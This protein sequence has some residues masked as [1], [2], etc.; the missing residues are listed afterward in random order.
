MRR[1][2]WPE[3]ILRALLPFRDLSWVEIGEEFTR[4]TLLWTPFF[5]IYLHRMWS[6][7]PAAKCHDHPWSFLSIPLLRGYCEIIPGDTTFVTVR[8]MLPGMIKWHPA[9]YA[10]NTFTPF[11]ISWSMILTGSKSHKWGF[12]SC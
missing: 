3:K 10:H 6:P 4:W 9:E 2:T 8:A 12:K 7:F 11:G 5:A 1:L